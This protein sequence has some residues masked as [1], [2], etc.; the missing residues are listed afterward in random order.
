MVKKGLLAV[1]SAFFV[2]FLVSAVSA[3]ISVSEP[4]SAYNVGDGYNFTISTTPGANGNDFLSVKLFCSSIGNASSEVEIYKVPTAIS[5]GEEKVTQISGAF[6][7][8]L[9]G[10]LEGRCYV[11][12]RYMGEA[13]K[14]ESF[15]LT[16][17][18]DV[19]FDAVKG[20]FDPGEQIIVSGNVLKVSGEAVEG[21]VEA[22]LVSTEINAVGGVSAGKFSVSLDLPENMR[23][24]SY[25]LRIKAYDRDEFGKIK[26]E[27]TSGSIIRVRQL[28][29]SV[30]IAFSSEQIKPGNSL[31]YTVLLYDQAEEEADQ[32]SAVSIRDS[33]DNLVLEKVVVGGESNEFE[34]A[35]NYT[36]GYWKLEARSSG[37]ENSRQ[38]FVEENE[39]IAFIL[40]N[41]SLTIT[42]IGNVQ[43]NKPVE[44]AIG[45]VRE[46]KDVELGVGE[47]KKFIL[48]APDGE[49]SIEVADGEKKES[50][51][52]S[53]LTGN[54]IR[55][56][57]GSPGFWRSSA[58]FIWMILIAGAAMAA[59]YYFDRAAN[60]AYVG[61]TPVSEPIKV[62][63]IPSSDS[64]DNIITDGKREE[65]SVISLKIENLAEGS[66]GEAAGA[67]ESA[68]M[69]AK[70]ANAKIFSSGE[71]KTIIFAPLVT[72]EEDNSMRAIKT[73]KEV[74][75]VLR[76]YNAGTNDKIKYG[77]GVHNL[78][79]I[80]S[81]AEGR[82]KFNTIDSSMTILKNIAEK[83]HYDV[84]IS[85]HVHRKLLG[86]IKDERIGGDNFWRIRKVMQRDQYSDFINK[87]LTKQKED[88]RKR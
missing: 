47:S 28:V 5:A 4:A 63:G 6:D 30:E 54:A 82:F 81:A 20:T 9:V 88:A 18:L 2:I 19:N 67:I 27:G 72:K 34:V 46:I 71:F 29:K 55:I 23:S 80:L 26:N 22:Q 8:F 70:G 12:A 42:N 14:S 83:A 87:F 1:V 38:F 35:S 21:F 48:S 56:E 75:D 39:E 85:G 40:I 59:F 15:G 61:K 65:C 84:G 11:E 58:L 50:L 41:D 86:Q 32:E 17:N 76:Q 3:K 10:N 79:L 62:G 52:T 78:P 33:S 69:K 64:K 57:E 44:I 51:G 68:L 24:G 43:Y 7:N 36:P 16:R 73:A 13:A 31:S 49:Y 45:E 74:E 66:K 25:E 37:V 60:R 53:F 77:I